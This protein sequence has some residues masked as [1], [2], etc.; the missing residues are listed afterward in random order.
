MLLQELRIFFAFF[1]ST[2]GLSVQNLRTLN[3]FNGLQI[4]FVCNVKQLS[5]LAYCLR[6]NFVKSRDFAYGERHLEMFSR[7]QIENKKER[8]SR[9][10]IGR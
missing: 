4:V 3:A 10:K 9:K 5:F 2:T 1:G 6:Y 7:V 8:F